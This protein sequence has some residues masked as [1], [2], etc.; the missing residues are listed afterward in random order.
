MKLCKECKQNLH[1]FNFDYRGGGRKDRQH[2]CKLCSRLRLRIHRKL[3]R[4]K[5]NRWKEKMGCSECGFMGR[6][7]QLDLDHVD[8]KTKRNKGNSRAYEP[9]WKWGRVEE[10]LRKCVILCANCH[11]LKTFEH[12]EHDPGKR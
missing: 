4:D 5:V 9:S 1:E 11:R 6:H 2:V 8:P 7:F 3:V 10:E 12:D